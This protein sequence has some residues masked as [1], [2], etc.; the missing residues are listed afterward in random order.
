M[1]YLVA[2]PL[3]ILLGIFVSPWW[4][5]FGAVLGVVGMFLI[6]YRRLAGVW[7]SL[8][9]WEKIRAAWWVPIIRVTGDIAKM[10]G[11]PV[12]LKWR[13]ERLKTHPEL[14]WR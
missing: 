9:T 13:L 7:S 1:T 5:L 3:L 10:T 2:L 8:S 12:G 11:Y 14:S 4:W 6:P